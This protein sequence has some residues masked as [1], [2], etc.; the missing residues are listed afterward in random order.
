MRQLPGICWYPAE[1]TG[2]PV[3]QG[4]IADK[5]YSSLTEDWF[6]WGHFYFP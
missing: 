4:G 3:N 2:I 1:G 5:L 6:C